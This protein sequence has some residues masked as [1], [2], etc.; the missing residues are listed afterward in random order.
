MCQGLQCLLMYESILQEQLRETDNRERELRQEWRRNGCS[1]IL[2]SWKSQC[3]KSYISVLVYC[4]KGMMFLRSMDVSTI[5]EDVD[6]LME[7]LLRVVNDVGAHNIVQIITNDVSSYMQTARHYVLKHYDHPFFF[8]LCADHCIN[9]LLEKVAASKNVSEVLMKA[10]E[11]TRFIYSHALPMELKGRYV[12]EEI[13]S[14][15]SLKFVAVFITLER[16]VSARVNLVNMFNSSAWDSSVWAA[17]NLFRH[18]SGIVK[19]DDVFWRAAADVVKVTNPLVS[20]LYKLETDICPMGILY[21]AMDSAKEDIKRNLGGKHGDY[22]AEIDRIWDGYLHSPL[23]AAGH[24]L[25]PRIFYSDRFLY[26]AE[27]SSGIM[28]CTIQLGQVHYKPRKAAA[29]LEIYHKKLGSFNSVPAFQQITGIP[30]VQWWSA[31]GARTPDLQTMAK[32]ILSQTCFG[33]TRY[34]IDW[35]LSEK[36]HVGRLNRTPLEHKTFC[37]MEYVHYNLFLTRATPC[38]HG[39]SYSG[40]DSAG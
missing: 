29:Q 33:A 3:G 24:L 35:S 2:D 22:W 37:Q 39:S 15:S 27:I 32:R 6:L 25:N 26:D 20:M 31:H 13:L 18:I 38:L 23:H 28:I 16:L 11:I 34:N 1:V 21:D 30:Q 7:M 14:S 12:Q 40:D 5:I 36:L 17:S 8:T 10:K 4:S 19:T 9:L